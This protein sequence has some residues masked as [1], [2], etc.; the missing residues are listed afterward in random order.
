MILDL[1]IGFI[2]I[3]IGFVNLYINRKY[4][5]LNLV[6]GFLFICNF[7][8][9]NFYILANQ[10]HI[11]DSKNL[12]G[13]FRYSFNSISYL[14]TA[15]ISLLIFEAVRFFFINNSKNKIINIRFIDNKFM[16]WSSFII[17]I[18]ILIFEVKRSSEVAL[19]LYSVRISALYEYGKIFF[20]LLY[21]SSGNT[22]NKKYISLILT[23]LYIIQDFIY[24]G[25]VS[26]IQVAIIAFL[27]FFQ[28]I[29]PLKLLISGFFLFS[30]SVFVGAVRSFGVLRLSKL[31]QLDFSFS[32]IINQVSQFSTSTWS[33]FASL[34]QVYS[35]E[36]I[37]IQ[38]RIFSFFS[39][40]IKV[41]TGDSF[42]L[43]FVEKDL[44]NVTAIS[45]EYATNLGGGLIHSW[46]Y[47]W[48]GYLGV[49]FLSIVQW[50]LFT[51]L[52]KSKNDLNFLIL[53]LLLASI[54]RWYLYGPH[55]FYRNSLVI[56]PLVFF[57]F[58]LCNSII[59]YNSREIKKSI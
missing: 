34:T 52:W 36:F 43:K 5:W 16:F 21:Y 38:D 48:G 50:K 56:L 40:I 44:S 35:V 54:P 24:G 14:T 59:K 13:E 41:F 27:F 8:I 39:F 15:L 53:I 1:V 57:L 20:L 58:K 42:Y 9:V 29:K 46:Y 22:K 4:N 2:I 55:T 32:D 47:F 45:S 11:L 26:A 6:N 19:D 7:S 10:T 30:L 37:S 28:N 33:F 23:L 17:I 31:T 18:Y 3:I 12:T 25:R 51:F 49:F